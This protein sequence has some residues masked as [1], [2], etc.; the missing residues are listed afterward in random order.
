MIVVTVFAVPVF[1]RAVIA[2][3]VPVFFDLAAGNAQERNQT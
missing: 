3:P 1:G 2:A